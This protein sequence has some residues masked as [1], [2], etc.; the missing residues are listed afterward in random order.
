[1]KESVFFLCT[2]NS[3][4]SQMAEGMLRQ[5]AGD[6]FEVYSAG[7]N[8]THIHPL[9]I[10]VME[11][12]GIDISK[13]RSKSVNEFLNRQFDCVITV[14]DN[15]RQS[16][17]FFPGTY[18]LLHWGLEDPAEAAG[19]EEEKLVIFRKVR[20]RPKELSRIA[21]RTADAENR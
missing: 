21:A 12:M 2:G 7:V 20:R 17:P 9:A 19:T 4:R 13:Q 3:C 8:P 18:E 14:C 1:M 10:K 5:M 11:E 16:C 6:R 15:A